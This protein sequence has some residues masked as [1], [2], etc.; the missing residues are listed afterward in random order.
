MEI[1]YGVNEH[2]QLVFANLDWNQ[3]AFENGAPHLEEAHVLGKSLWDFV[4]DGV[5]RQ[6]YRGALE[7]ARRGFVIDLTLRCDAPWERR[8]IQMFISPGI[9]ADIEFR[10]RLLCS[11]PRP[12]QLL[13]EPTAPRSRKALFLCCWCNRVSLGMAEW[14]EVEEASERLRLADAKEFPCLEYVTCPCCFAK[15]TAILE[16]ATGVA[17]FQAEP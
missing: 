14:L 2:D 5:T 4:G 13:L 12:V 11:K 15:I 10:T 3:F 1:A 17:K 8:L 6:L 7:Q 9:R 16:G